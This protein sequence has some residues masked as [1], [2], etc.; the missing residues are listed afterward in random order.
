MIYLP[1]VVDAP[2]VTKYWFNVISSFSVSKNVTELMPNSDF[3]LDDDTI[4]IQFL[5]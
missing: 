2:P 3:F 5:Y 1:S 4:V